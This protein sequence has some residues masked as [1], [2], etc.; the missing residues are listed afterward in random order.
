MIGG[1][2]NMGRDGSVIKGEIKSGH[3]IYT[4]RDGRVA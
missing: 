4:R 2:V 1:L 3:E